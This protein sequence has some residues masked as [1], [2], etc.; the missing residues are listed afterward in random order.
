MTNFK[1][2]Y[3][4]YKLKYLKLIG[5]VIE[6][7]LIAN[8]RP[9]E[10]EKN[11]GTVDNMTNQCLWISICDYIKRFNIELTVRELRNLLI[12][13]KIEINNER[14]MADNG[15]HQLEEAF[16]LIGEIFNLK[17]KIFPIA[18][19]YN[20]KKYINKESVSVYGD[21]NSNK[22]I[23]IASGG[24]TFGNHFELITEIFDK[25]IPPEE[26]NNFR[27]SIEKNTINQNEVELTFQPNEKKPMGFDLN[28]KN[29]V[30]IGVTDQGHAFKKGMQIGD[31]IIQYNYENVNNYKEYLKIEGRINPNDPI[32][33]TIKKKDNV[34][35]KS[36][37][38]LDDEIC[39]QDLMNSNLK[40]KEQESMEN[41]NYQITF[42]S[43][44]QKPMMGF[45][46]NPNNLVIMEA[47]GKA[48]NKGMRVGDQIIE[49]NNI[50]VNN[51]QEY[52]DIKDNLYDTNQIITLRLKRFEN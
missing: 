41:D 37:V 21:Q 19:E 8:L 27:D 29:L 45:S 48:Y 20:N 52:I 2:K 24:I 28:D 26:Y 33:L 38:N 34:K 3:I 46:Y 7:A 13:H 31:Q 35:K 25:P 40:T 11:S 42:N 1:K 6:D 14:E 44:E 50:P 22:V 18:Y 30:I 10:T 12:G 23:N 9:Y 47:S 49:F 16:K 4:K 32:V 43:D 15:R 39:E 36:Y 5:G 51:H 17:I